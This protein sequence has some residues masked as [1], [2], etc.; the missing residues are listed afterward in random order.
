MPGKARYGV[1][2]VGYSAF[3]IARKYGRKIDYAHLD[4]EA[5][6]ASIHGDGGL[7]IVPNRTDLGP[8]LKTLPEL[9]NELRELLHQGAAQMPGEIVGSPQIG[10]ASCRERV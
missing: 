5:G 6:G 1:K 4:F 2:F 9:A 10:R 3:V 7:V 8:F